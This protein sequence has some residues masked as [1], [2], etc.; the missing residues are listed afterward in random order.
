M[1]LRP[2]IQLTAK[3]KHRLFQG[4]QSSHGEGERLGEV[5]VNVPLLDESSPSL[6]HIDH[7]LGKRALDLFLNRP[8][9]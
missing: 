4:V 9:G 7:V 5:N 3:A 1:I 6:R 2:F 8:H